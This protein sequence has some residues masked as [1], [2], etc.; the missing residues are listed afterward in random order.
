MWIA[1]Y[2]SPGLT[3]KVFSN[4]RRIGKGFSK[5]EAPLFDTIDMYY[6]V[7]KSYLV[8]TR[9]S[10]SSIRD[11]QAQEEGPEVSEEEEIQVFWFKEIKKCA[12]VQ[13]RT[14]DV[15]D[16]KEVNAAEP[17]VFD[18]EEV[19]MTMAQPLIKMKAKKVRL[20]NEQM[21]KRLH[22]E[23]VKQA[24]AREKQ[25]KDDLEKAKES[26]KKLKAVEVL[27]S[28]S[29][30][31]TLTHDPKETSKEDVKNMLEII[32]VSKFKVK[33]LQVKHPLIDWEIYYEGSRSYWKIIR[34]DGITEAYQSFEYMLKGF[35]R[36]DLDALW[37][38]V[39]EKFSSAMPTEDKE[40][41][42]W[43]DAKLQVDEDCEMARDLVM[44][45][46]MEANKPKS[47]RLDTS[48]K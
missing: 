3:Q 40:K 16:A 9:Q 33:A 7:P 15:S 25:E 44:K 13:R 24:V 42:L 26:F 19:T 17:T 39:K 4:M 2:T 36:E 46:L 1:L 21:A 23:E 22:N 29:T 45:I 38:L 8:G 27:G 12:E 6:I 14:D 30:Q 37:K 47:R 10:C 43:V 35:D 48:S 28:H 34:V 31:D 32:L 20:L 18:D 41:S 5:V 11:F